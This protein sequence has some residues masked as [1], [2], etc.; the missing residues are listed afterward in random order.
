MD[1]EKVIRGHV[2]RSLYEWGVNGESND[3]VKLRRDTIQ[4]C[5][6]KVR[7][8]GYQG[9]SYY[10]DLKS[11]KFPIGYE[12][13]IRHIFEDEL[14]DESVIHVTKVDKLDMEGRPPCFPWYDRKNKDKIV[15]YRRRKGFER[16][17]DE[18]LDP[19]NRFEWEVYI[20]Q[21]HL[22][23]QRWFLKE[24]DSM[25]GNVFEAIFVC[26][27]IQHEQCFYCKCRNCLRWNGGYKTAWQDLVCTVCHSCYELKT[28]KDVDKIEEEF[29]RNRIPGGSFA[30]YYRLRNSI[31]QDQKLFLVVL[32]RTFCFDPTVGKFYPVYCVEIDIVIP[33][34]QGNHFKPVKP[35]KPVDGGNYTISQ[36]KKYDGARIKSFVKVKSFPQKLRDR[37]WF[38]LPR[39]KEPIGWGD[40][41]EDVYIKKFGE[42]K[43]HSYLHEYDMFHSYYGA[44]DEQD[45]GTA[46]CGPSED[47]APPA[48]LET[49]DAAHV[50]QLKSELEGLK[51]GNDEEDDWE[52][53]FDDDD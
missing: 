17:S 34:L 52:T 11:K 48:K 30:S 43:F 23:F 47:T 1:K 27:T 18:E 44:S 42:E 21:S 9:G 41:I 49:G 38:R 50:D 16:F 45:E 7:S 13:A 26:H 25:L 8:Q 22:W 32:P 12:D 51:T 15:A 3:H 46:P 35:P 20:D 36:R 28:K 14:E 31:K 19:L 33:E 40:I 39:W 4:Q 37:L 29:N 10:E 2:I 24:E 6:E 5:M 53:M